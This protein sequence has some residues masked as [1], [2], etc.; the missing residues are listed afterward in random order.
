MNLHIFLQSVISRA[1][2]NNHYYVL[3]SLDLSSAFDIVNRHLLF[4]RLEIFGLPEDVRLLIENWLEERLFYVE[5]AGSSST[6][7]EDKSGTIQGS[8]LGPVLFCLFIRP[9]FEI[10]DLTTYADDNYIGIN[11]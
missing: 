9:L 3:S 4:K 5:C 11:L 2:N 7:H 8:V 1:L 10:E 6:I